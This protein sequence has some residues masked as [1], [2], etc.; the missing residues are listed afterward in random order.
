[1]KKEIINE[2]VI[3][4]DKVGDIEFSVK[5][6]TYDV[7]RM[8]ATLLMSIKDNKKYGLYCVSFT[9]AAHYLE[10][11]M[12]AEKEA[13]KQSKRASKNSITPQRE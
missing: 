13:E 8:M 1:M 4:Q 12:K 3:R 2:I 11:L 6:N 5:G 9:S 10:E 7:G